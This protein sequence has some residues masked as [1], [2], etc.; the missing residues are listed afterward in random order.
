[1]ISVVV[2]IYFKKSKKKTVLL[3]MNWYRNAHYTELDRAKKFIGKIV[4]DFVDGEPI[5]EGTIHVHYKIYWKRAGTDGG[6]VRSVIEK[7]VLD[8]IQTEE[9]ITN[10]NAEIIVTDSSEYHRDK[11]FPRAEITLTKK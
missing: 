7:F 6:N 2:P 10:D 11:K 4:K 8:A 9:L 5:L 1:M 3:G